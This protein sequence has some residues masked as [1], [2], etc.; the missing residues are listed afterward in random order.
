EFGSPSVHNFGPWQGHDW[1]VDEQRDVPLELCPASGECEDWHLLTERAFLAHTIVGWPSWHGV[2]VTTALHD[3]I[4]DHAS[5]A[6]QTA[7]ASIDLAAPAI[8]GS[9]AASAS[10][11][12]VSA[13]ASTSDASPWPLALAFG[14]AAAIIALGLGTRAA[15][16]GRGRA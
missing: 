13:A 4:L 9:P 10:S 6:L 11:T 7:N 16:Q 2:A 14:A 3:V 1:P 12:L 8:E 15:M 5:P